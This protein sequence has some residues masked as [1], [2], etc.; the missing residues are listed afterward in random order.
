MRRTKFL[1]PVPVCGREV[2]CIL[3]VKKSFFGKVNKYFRLFQSSPFDK[4][5][6]KQTRN[7]KT[8]NLPIMPR[9][10]QA[11]AAEMNMRITINEPWV[12]D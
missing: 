10:Q 6:S 3:H 4:E 7:V 9:A 11:Y 8:I 1:G 12:H 2:V 5:M